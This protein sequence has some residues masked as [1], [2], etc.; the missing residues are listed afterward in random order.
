MIEQAYLHMKELID[1]VEGKT[2]LER[3]W[4]QRCKLFVKDLKTWTPEVYIYLEDNQINY[5][6]AS[7]RMHP[8]VF[9]YYNERILLLEDDKAFEKKVLDWNTY[10]EEGIK[11]GTLKIITENT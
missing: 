6:V 7:C 4:L 2:N 1:V 8:N 10:L 11:K 9:D 5:I 3:G